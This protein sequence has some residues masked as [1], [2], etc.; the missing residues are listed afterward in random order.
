MRVLPPGAG[1]GVQGPIG[2]VPDVHGIIGSFV[3]R[4]PDVAAVGEGD[5]VGTRGVLVGE[6]PLVPVEVEARPLPAQGVFGEAEGAPAHPLAVG[7][8]AAAGLRVERQAL[9]PRGEAAQRLR[10][11]GQGVLGERGEDRGKEQRQLVLRSGGHV[12]RVAREHDEQ[13]LVRE[14][15]GLL[16]AHAQERKAVVPDA[17]DLVAIARAVLRVVAEEGVVHLAGGGAAH[18]LPRQE[19][20]PVDLAPAHAEVSHLGQI[21]RAGQHAAAAPGVAAGRA[22]ALDVLCHAHGLEHAGPERL[23]E[24]GARDPLDDHREH[25]RAGRVVLE[26]RARAVGGRRLKIGAD[27]VH[28]RLGLVHVVGGLVVAVG[29]AQQVLHR[30][31]PQ[32]GVHLRLVVLGEEVRHAVGEAQP[33]FAAEDAH[34]QGDEGLGAGVEP[35]RLAAGHGAVLPVED[36]RAAADDGE[37]VQ[38]QREVLQRVRVAQ[39]RVGGNADALGRGLCKGKWHRNP[40]FSGCEVQNVGRPQYST[41]GAKTECP[42]FPPREKKRG[43]P[44]LDPAA[45]AL[46]TEK[47]IPPPIGRE[48]RRRKP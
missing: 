27:P 32:E 39:D 1:K 19:L 10:V 43:R 9:A 28:V 11:L 6:G 22:H 36:D 26:D 17:P 29:H 25:D 23:Q 15:E 47:E 3:K 24:R 48:K 31:L 33:S 4:L 35:V 42:S 12:L 18:V 41:N 13:V 45:S 14:A 16:A 34:G 44:A 2:R 8:V 30:G 37:R 5:A 40:P 20:P 46:Y 7:R 21:L 38:A